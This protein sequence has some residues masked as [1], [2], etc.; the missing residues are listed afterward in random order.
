MLSFVMSAVVWLFPTGG[1][2]T[3]A[4]VIALT[5]SLFRCYY[6]PTEPWSEAESASTISGFSRSSTSASGIQEGSSEQEV[7]EAVKSEVQTL[8]V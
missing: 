6:R 8:M 1:C 4:S 7:D 2:I 5:P 3:L